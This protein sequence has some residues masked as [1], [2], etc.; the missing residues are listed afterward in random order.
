MQ[1]HSLITILTNKFIYF[2]NY[3]SDKIIIAKQYRDWKERRFAAPSPTYVKK[4]VIL[5]NG[6]ANA[7]WVETGTYKGDTSALISVNSKQVYT[8]EPADQLFTDAKQRFSTYE[9]VEVI[10]GTSEN[11]FPSLLPTLKGNI[12]FWLDGHYSTGITFQ[13]SKDCPLIEEL[14]EIEKNLSNFPQI[15]ILIDDVR[16]CVNPQVHQFSGYPKLDTLVAWA[17]RNGLYWHIE[18]DTMIIKNKNLYTANDV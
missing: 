14:A 8:I 4:Q 12:N 5:R 7:I 9:N 16:Y 13:G 3:Y 10:H 1:K 17:L 11:I 2:L 6:L 18:H 15:V